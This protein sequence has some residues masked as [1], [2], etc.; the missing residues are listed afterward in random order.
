MKLNILIALLFLFL[1]SCKT[2]DE[3]KKYTSNDSSTESI[4]PSDSK[5][6]G[7][8]SSTVETDETTSGTGSITYHFIIKNDT[9]VLTTTT[10]H[11]PIR[12]NGNYK[13]VENNG[14]LEL[15]YAG[16]E[17]SCQSKTAKFK[18]KH[19]N[20]KYY[21]QGLGGEA[22]FNEWIELLKVKIEKK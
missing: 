4:K 2:H 12:C 5:F 14:I 18:I 11:E 19:E 17:E 21:I 6:Q 8:F 1:A 10:Y 13:A 3:N 9:A 16:N 7:E 22:T 20:N 15:F